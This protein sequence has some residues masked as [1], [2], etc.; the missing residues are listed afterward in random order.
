MSPND[1]IEIYPVNKKGDTIGFIK[2]H[3][4]NNNQILILTDGMNNTQSNIV[5]GTYHGGVAYK[6]TVNQLEDIYE[7]CE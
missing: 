5:V 2:I 3:I 4:T 1:E 7:E 6:Q